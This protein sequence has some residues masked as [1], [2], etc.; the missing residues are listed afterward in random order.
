M[1]LICGSLLIQKNPFLG[2]VE[3]NP[4]LHQLYKKLRKITLVIIAMDRLRL[5]SRLTSYGGKWNFWV[6]QINWGYVH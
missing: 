2:R 4:P 6:T 5:L 1:T 3:F